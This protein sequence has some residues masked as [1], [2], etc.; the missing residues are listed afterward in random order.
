MAD[1]RVLLADGGDELPPEER[2]RRERARESAAGI[3][4]YA[5]D[6]GHRVA[7]AAL[8]GQLV[9][10]DLRAGTAAIVAVPGP[11]VDPRP[12]PTGTRVAW[13][14]GRALW[15]AELGDPASAR[16]VAEEDD[17]EVRW[18]VA[19]F[20]A[21]EEMDRY[22]GYWWSP[23]GTALLVA[24][25]DDSPVQRWWIADPARP[26]Q[27]PTEVAYPVAGTPNADVSAWLLRLD[28]TRTE[29][30]WD[31][32]RLALPRA[33]PAGTSTAPSSR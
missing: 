16:A 6:A 29:V 23:D 18:G 15:V 7:V 14:R 25:V 27:A 9:V 31:R 5:T 4:A 11:V 33:R 3:T 8:A 24:R 21:A 12:D 17:P 22:R 28:G 13:V 2:V 30:T 10:A 20:V 19:E 26:D 32:T 1:P